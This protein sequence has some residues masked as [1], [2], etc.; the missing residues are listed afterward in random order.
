M[1]IIRVFLVS[2]EFVSWFM[3]AKLY[4]LKLREK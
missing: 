1:C 2:A 3:Y 4:I